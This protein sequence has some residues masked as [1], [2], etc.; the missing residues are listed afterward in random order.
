MSKTRCSSLN[1]ESSAYLIRC[2]TILLRILLAMASSVTP[3]QF[4]VVSPFFVNLTRSHF[5]CFS[6][7]S[8]FL[9]ILLRMLYMA[10]TDTTPTTPTYPPRR[11]SNL[12]AFDGRS[13]F[14][15]RN[16]I[17]PYPEFFS[18]L[19]GKW[20]VGRGR[21]STSSKCSFQR[22]SCSSTFVR[23]SPS[24]LGIGFLRLGLRPLRILVVLQSV[25]RSPFLAASSASVAT[26]TG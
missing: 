17:R 22:V 20:F 14:G 19:Q 26:C 11:L 7:I 5:F 2:S 16:V 13:D 3:L 10:S 6:G 12:E 21:L 8:S 25:L 4:C 15:P 1:N 18:R 9:Q 24:P 23:M